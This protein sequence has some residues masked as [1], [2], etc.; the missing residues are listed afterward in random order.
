MRDIDFSA[1]QDP[2]GGK[3]DP[4]G[5]PRPTQKS[6]QEW[7]VKA[8]VCGY[9]VSAKPSSKPFELLQAE[10]KL[11]LIVARTIIPTLVWP[12]GISTTSSHVRS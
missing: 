4:S 3:T 1:A 5:S 9:L 7:G 11:Q 2:W 8:I 6:R 12:F 10:D